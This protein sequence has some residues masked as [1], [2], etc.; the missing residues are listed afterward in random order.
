MDTSIRI[1]DPL[2]GKQLGQPLRGHSKYITGIAWE[3]LH[4]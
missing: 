1:W 4:L 2:T 3:P